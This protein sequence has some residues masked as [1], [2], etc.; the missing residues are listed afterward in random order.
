MQSKTTISY[1]H[2]P[3]RMVKIKIVTLNADEDAEQLNDFSISSGS[4]SGV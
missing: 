2:I 1:Y 4:I 3:I